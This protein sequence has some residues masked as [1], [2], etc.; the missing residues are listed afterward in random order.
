MEMG[1]R[2]EGMVRYDYEPGMAFLPDHGGGLLMPQVYCAPIDTQD[3]KGHVRFTDDVIFAPE[4]K[5]LFQV[6]VLLRNLG[7]VESARR[8]LQDLDR[9]SDGEIRGDEATFIIHDPYIGHIP[10]MDNLVLKN[11]FRIATANEFAMDPVLCGQRPPPMYYD[12]Y[13]MMRDVGNKM[14]VILRP[15]RF[16]FA[17]CNERTELEEAAGRIRGVLYGHGR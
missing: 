12:E 6:V 4:K 2:R 7:D 9:V 10:K 3:R 1:S 11:V 17:A 8:E 15:D 5:G 14:F 16:V 13:R